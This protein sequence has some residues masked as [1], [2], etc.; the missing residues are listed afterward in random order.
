MGNVSMEE[1]ILDSC[2]GLPTKGVV[3]M[4]LVRIAFVVLLAGCSATGVTT[5]GKNSFVISQHA[6][7]GFQSV[8]GIPTKVM[9][10]ATSYCSASDKHVVIHNMPSQDGVPGQTL[11]PGALGALVSYSTVNLTFGCYDLDDPIYIAAN[12]ERSSDVVF[13]ESQTQDK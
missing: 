12:P 10:E 5:T 7:S 8:V 1:Y 4:T 6:A 11:Q 13:E 2:R 3:D 9:R